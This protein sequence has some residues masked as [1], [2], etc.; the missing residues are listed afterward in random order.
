[1]LKIN[2]VTKRNT[3]V[4]KTVMCKKCKKQQIWFNVDT[5]TLDFAANVVYKCPKCNTPGE[6]YI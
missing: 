5:N 1:M 6:E 4:K 3:M 2:L